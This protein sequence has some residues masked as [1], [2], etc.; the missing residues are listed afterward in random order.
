MQVYIIWGIV[1]LASPILKFSP[2]I[3]SFVQAL[4]HNGGEKNYLEYLFPRPKQLVTSLFAANAILIGKL[5]LQRYSSFVIVG[6][7]YGA[8]NS[9]IFA[10]YTLASLSLGPSPSHA[11]FSPVR[12][13]AFVC[14]TA[15]IALHGLH[16]RAGIQLQ[17]LL[18]FV[19]IGIFFV[20]VVSGFIALNGN[21]Q[22]GVP[23]PGNLDSWE[24]IWDGSRTEAGVLCN[25]LYNVR[26]H[27]SEPL[28][29]T[30]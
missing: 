5:R 17:N 4:P 20:V 23:R 25:A 10:E 7:G 26:A 24:Q 1:R 16:I 27:F 30:T 14:V 13:V 11:I 2:L 3:N 9:L 21:L 28:N 19:K 15:V 29:P 18:G 8:A 22:E 6:L 12:L